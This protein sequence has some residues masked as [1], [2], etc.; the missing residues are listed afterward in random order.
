M[1]NV[2]LPTDFSDNAWKAMSYAAQLFHGKVCNFILLN[3]FSIPYSY[4]EAAVMPNIEPLKKDSELGLEEVLQRF[5]EFDHNDDSTFKTISKMASLVDS[6]ASIASIASEINGECVI[7]MGTKGA[8]G[9]GD[10]F[11]GTMT[12]HV[13]NH[14]T[15]PVICVPNL[16]KLSTPKNI[17]LTVDSEGVNRMD[18]IQLLIDLAKQHDSAIKVV[19]VPMGEDEVLAADSSEQF[20]VDH[21]LKQIPHSYHT[22]MGDYKEDLLTQFAERNDIDL[23]AM[24]K[25]NRGFWKNL[26]HRS[27]TKNMSFYCEK[28]LLILRD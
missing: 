20:V 8:S 10:T 7:V 25:R 6:I 12:S 1:K 16:A 13:I 27:L 23:I 11:L 17:M 2:I 14:S 15:L 4:S 22:L 28:P 18:E 3:T 26:F 19:N 9:L 5:K 24:I 21:Y